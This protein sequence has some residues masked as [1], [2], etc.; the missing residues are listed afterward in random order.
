VRLRPSYAEAHN[1][2]GN[3]LKA[4]D[5]LPEAAASYREAVRLWPDLAEAHNN[6]GSALL[7][8]RRP[9]EAESSLRQALRHRP[10]FAAAHSNLGSALLELRRPEEAESSLRQAIRFDPHSAEAHNTLAGTYLAQGRL[11]EAVAAYRQAVRLQPDHAEAHSNLGIMLL[12]KGDFAE[13]WPEY[14]WRWKGKGWSVPAGAPP[15]WDGSALE[16]RTIL[17]LTEQGLGDTIH[18]VRYAALVKSR[19]GTVV[20]ACQK[21]LTRLLARAPGIDQLVPADEP[22]PETDVYA[23]LLSLPRL[24]D[25]T[26]ASVPA[27][28]PYL[29]P[30]PELV[31]RWK[32]ELGPPSGLRVG[33]AWQGN[34]EYRKDRERSVPLRQFEPLA[35]LEGVQLVSLQKGQGVEQIAEMA[36]RFSILDLGSRFDDFA[37]TAAALVHLDL[38]VTV[39]SAVAH[40]AGALGVPVWLALP[41]VPDWRWL[42]DRDDSPWYPTMRL[43]RQQKR[44]DWP[45]VFERITATLRNLLARSGRG[46]GIRVDVSAGELVDKITILEIKN[47]RIQDPAKLDDVRREL[48]TLRQARAAALPAGEQLDDLTAQLRAVNETLLDVEDKIRA[49]EAQ[50]DFGPRFIELARSVYQHNDHRTALKRRIDDLLG[51]RLV[52]EKAD[53]VYPQPPAAP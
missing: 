52:E 5:R 27:D 7:E 21:A 48:A 25:T 16:G 3:T 51:S 4:L 43:F 15:R 40:L 26:L 29:T 6:L 20:L 47:T 38:V 22:V 10:D 31:E 19:G 32:R 30:E 39:D 17:L 12:M 50:S 8:L 53:T 35:R 24:L 33:I 36:G 34:P 42:L 46:G 28:V 14:E 1:N 2:L 18:L 44:G 9:E 37:A 41:F 49:C 23:P 11:E 13:G 45:G